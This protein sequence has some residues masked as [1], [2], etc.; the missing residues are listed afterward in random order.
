MGFS[1]AQL[2]IGALVPAIL[3]CVANDDAS[4]C[5][6][7]SPLVQCSGPQHGAEFVEELTDRGY[8]KYMNPA[9]TNGSHI[10][11][12]IVEVQ[13]RFLHL[14][15]VDVKR[16]QVTVSGYLRAWWQDPRLAF[17]T[18]AEGGCFDHID[19][20]EDHASDIWLPSFYIA[21]LAGADDYTEAFPSA[22]VHVSPD[23]SVWTSRLVLV[24]VDCKI[25]LRYL[26]YDR[27]RCGLSIGSYSH[28][29]RYVRLLPREGVLEY[30]ESGVGTVAVDFTGAIWRPL[31]FESQ[32]DEYRVPGLVEQVNGYDL[33]TLQWDFERIPG[34]YERAFIVPSQLF[35][36]LSYMQFYVDRAAAPARAALATIPVLI[37][38]TL[39][40][41]LYTSLPEGSQTMWI[42]DLFRAV[43]ILCVCASLQFGVVQV[44]QVQEKHCLANVAALNRVRS[45]AQRLMELADE[46]DSS[47][48]SILDRHAAREVTIRRSRVNQDEQSRVTS[49]CSVDE[50]QREAVGPAADADAPQDD[51]V[52]TRWARSPEAVAHGIREADLM[53]IVFIKDIFLHFRSPGSDMMGVVPFRNSLTHFQIYRSHGDAACIICMFLR[54]SGRTTDSKAV[55]TESLGFSEYMALLMKIDTYTWHTGWVKSERWDPRQHLLKWS[56]AERVDVLARWIF[57]L[58]I[59]A[60]DLYF[61]VVA[62]S[63]PVL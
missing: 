50:F 47:L 52:I 33:A 36:G 2:L 34:Y 42:S 10:G 16:S 61:Y 49:Q 1:N 15:S 23:G 58:L 14:S 59:L 6:G 43:L 55:S 30:G 22:M 29:N 7:V 21:N 17:N 3:P 13:M 27:H 48:L 11:P 25:N 41:M 24:T 26:P 35:L 54:D 57:G 9:C 60:I 39:L 32:D 45:A 19:L 56:P 28:P 8:D 5:P 37:Q 12:T 40:R 4:V 18:T 62:C 53:S 44:C 51:A 63:S 20:A 38:V 46:E 31:G